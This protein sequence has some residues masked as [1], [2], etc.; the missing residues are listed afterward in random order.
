M[1]M[2]GSDLGWDVLRMFKYIR[3]FNVVVVDIVVGNQIIAS[4]SHRLAKWSMVQ[5]NTGVKECIPEEDK[6]KKRIS[7]IRMRINLQIYSIGFCLHS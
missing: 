7:T 6:K 5:H 1:G 2:E 3:F 4:I